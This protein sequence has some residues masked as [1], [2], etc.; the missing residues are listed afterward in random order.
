MR[1][2]WTA[3]GACISGSTGPPKG[4]TSG[5]CGGA[6]TTSTTNAENVA[7]RGA[8]VALMDADAEF[9]TPFRGQKSITFGRRPPAVPSH[10]VERR[11]ALVNSTRSPSP[12]V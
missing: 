5:V 3:S 8:D 4:A 6:V 10:S 1:A 7:I 12:V 2:D 9:D 11:P